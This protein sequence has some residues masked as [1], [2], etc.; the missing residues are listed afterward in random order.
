MNNSKVKIMYKRSENIVAFMLGITVGMLAAPMKGA[1]VRSSLTY[2]LKRYKEN[3]KAFI[4]KLGK[5]GTD[6][7]N[8]AKDAGREVVYESITSAKK[9]LQEIDLLTAELEK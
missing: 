6:M 2:S 4:K 1:N 7:E 8:Q 3:L 9:L 5:H